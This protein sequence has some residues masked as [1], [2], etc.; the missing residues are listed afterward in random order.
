MK[1]QKARVLERKKEKEEERYLKLQEKAYRCSKC[2]KAFSMK[3]NLD[4]HRNSV[5]LR[6]KG[7]LCF[8]CEKAFSDKSLLEQH[9][10]SVYLKIKDFEKHGFTEGCE[11]C[12]RLRAGGMDARP[13]NAQCRQRMEEQLKREDNPRWKSA[14]ARMNE[15]IWEEIKK[16]DPVAAA[17]DTPEEENPRT[18]GGGGAATSSGG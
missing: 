11:G 15:K 16:N 10:K 6:I 18:G 8:D 17:E 1:A 13:H 9:R 7:F 5:H 2:E 14:Q 12:K 3:V 4:R